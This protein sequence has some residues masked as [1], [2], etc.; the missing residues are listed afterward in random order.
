MAK[1]ERNIVCF[2]N[3]EALAKND[4][5][6]KFGEF[7][8]GFTNDEDSSKAEKFFV[9]LFRNKPEHIKK[10][11]LRIRSVNFVDGTNAK[12]DAEIELDFD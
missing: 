12:E 3:I 2:A 5:T 1:K 9:D 10:I 4:S 11:K 7:G 8:I 6:I